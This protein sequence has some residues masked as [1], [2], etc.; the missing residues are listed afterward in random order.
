MISNVQLADLQHCIMNKSKILE[1]PYYIETEF[2]SNKTAFQLKANCPLSKVNKLR[3]GPRGW[4]RAGT[5]TWAGA[6]HR[7][8]HINRSSCGREIRGRVGGPML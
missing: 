5:G 6:R 8:P 4:V 7:G 2:T 1:N 3:T